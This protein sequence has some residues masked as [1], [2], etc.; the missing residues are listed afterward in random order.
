MKKSADSA[1]IPKKN[2]YLCSMLVFRVSPLQGGCPK[3]GRPLSPITGRCSHC[4]YIDG[5]N[6]AQIGLHL[7]D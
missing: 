4:G 7:D 3:C 6:A 2:A 1:F 5:C